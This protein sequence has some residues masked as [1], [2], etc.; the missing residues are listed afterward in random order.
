MKNRYPTPDEKRTLANITGLTMTQV[1]NWFKNRRQRDR[2]PA[3]CRGE[4]GMMGSPGCLVDGLTVNGDL[5]GDCYSPKSNPMFSDPR[6]LMPQIKMEPWHLT[7]AISGFP[8]YASHLAAAAST[9][10]TATAA[11]S[12]ETSG[13]DADA[14]GGG[15]GSGGGGGGAGGGVAS[16]VPASHSLSSGGSDGSGGR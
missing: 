5:H 1:S 4:L 15:I 2:T 13:Y 16:Q 12:A 10:T 3:S 11:A 14:I 9:S 7:S 6:N 8:S